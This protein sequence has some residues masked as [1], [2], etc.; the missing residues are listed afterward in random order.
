M[1]AYICSKKTIISW[2]LVEVFIVWLTIDSYLRGSDVLDVFIGTALVLTSPF[3]IY[4]LWRL[5]IVTEPDSLR[6][7]R[8]WRGVK[9]INW[10]SVQRVSMPKYNIGGNP[11]IHLFIKSLS[12]GKYLSPITSKNR[13][14][15]RI[16]ISGSMGRYKELLET[17]VNLSINA[18]IDEKIKKY[19]SEPPRPKGRAS[20]R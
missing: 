1:R 18:T 19:L 4:H 14:L 9:S 16:V 11:D 2:I 6:I 15:E 5:K 12:H 20:K 17:I 7:E 10:H 13:G 3:W 8:C